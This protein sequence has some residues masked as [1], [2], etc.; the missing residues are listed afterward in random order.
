VTNKTP[1]VVLI[2]T[3]KVAFHLSTAFKQ[4]GIKIVQVFGRQSDKAEALSKIS[5]ATFVTEIHKLQDDADLYLVAVLDQAVAEIAGLMPRTRGIVAHTS[6]FVDAEVFKPYFDN[7][8]VCYPLQTFTADRQLDYRDIPF[9]IEGS[10]M[11]TELALSSLAS[12]I[13]SSVTLANSDL[14][15]K[16]H[17]AAVFACNFPNYMHIIAHEIV[18]ET[19]LPFELLHPLML[20]TASKAVS[21]VP[22][23][24]Q[25]GPA[26]RH[27]MSTIEAHLNLIKRMGLK[28]EEVYALIT[29][30][31][32]EKYNKPNKQ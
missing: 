12:K 32:I 3:G 16:M 25:T 20:E 17:L 14:R 15:S 22:E 21:M 6:G 10:S 9:L 8:G 29:E 23:A 30:K 2:G 11:K 28:H 7:Y 18:H 31:I 24:A 13:S 27:D 19:G 5:G 4:A 26:A 1:T